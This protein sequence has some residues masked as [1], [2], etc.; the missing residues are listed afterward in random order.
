MSRIFISHSSANNTAA[1]ALASWLDA[2]GWSVYFLDIDDSRGIAPGERWMAALAGAVDRCEMVIFLVSQVWRNSKFCFAK[3]YQAK[4]LGK[5]IFGV[6]VEPIPLSQLPEQMTA[7]W[8]VCD[9]ANA[10]DPV[11]CTVVR[12]PTVHETV[13]SFPRAELEGLAGGMRKVGLAHRP[14]PV[15]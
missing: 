11:A 13:V 5:R 1:L 3:F 4:N 14:Y 9:L 8:Q 2:K 10:R 15:M 12:L 6:I 7:E